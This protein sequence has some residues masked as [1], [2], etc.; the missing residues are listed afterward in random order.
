MRLKV[1]VIV[2]LTKLIA[3][4]EGYRP[5]YTGLAEWNS[6]V[7]DSRFSRDPNQPDPFEKL[8]PNPLRSNKKPQKSQVAKLLQKVL[9]KD[10]VNIVEPEECCEDLPPYCTTPLETEVCKF[11]PDQ[12]RP[13]QCRC[14]VRR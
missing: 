7:K 6:I 1:I 12:H 2:L 13:N 9:G 10:D 3:Q 8:F 14:A 11:Y 5:G 4:A